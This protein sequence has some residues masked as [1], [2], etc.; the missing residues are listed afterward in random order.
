[1]TFRSGHERVGVRVCARVHA[2][3]ETHSNIDMVLQ[4]LNK[5]AVTR[6]GQREQAQQE[7]VTERG[8]ADEQARAKEDT[9]IYMPIM[10]HCVVKTASSSLN[11]KP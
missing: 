8:A 3:S 2:G 4:R 7:S 1:M 9:C 10:A 5:R 11:P 6:A